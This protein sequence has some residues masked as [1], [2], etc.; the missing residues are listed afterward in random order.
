MFFNSIIRQFFPRKHLGFHK[1]KLKKHQVYPEGKFLQD[2]LN[3]FSENVLNQVNFNKKKNIVC[4]GTCFAEEIANFLYR[5]SKNYKIYEENIFK[6]SINW[7]RVYTSQNLRQILDYSFNQKF[8]IFFKKGIN[9]YYDPLRDYACGTFQTKKKLIKDIKK[10]RKLSKKILTN[11]DQIFITLGQIDYWVEK[12]SNFIWGTIPTKEKDFS[13]KIRTKYSIKSETINDV[14]KN[15][16]YVIKK[17]KKINKKIKIIFT[18]SPVPSF[19]TFF[20]E[21]VIL[22]SFED[23]AKLKIAISNVVK[24]NSNV[25]YFPSF[26]KVMLGNNNFLIDNR[27]VKSKKVLEIFEVFKN[28]I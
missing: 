17:I 24:N 11:C 22:R 13:N 25:H 4:I 23:K 18:L 14:E 8:K 1:Y 16:L 21:N 27:H 6:F 10:H 26:E 9:G 2:S 3:E 28:Y 12:N 15:I 19:A 5:N 20:D 7:G